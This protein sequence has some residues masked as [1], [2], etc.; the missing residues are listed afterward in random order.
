MTRFRNCLLALGLATFLLPAAP[1][2]AGEPVAA[3]P[4]ATAPVRV[5]AIEIGGAF[6]RATLPGAPVAGGFLTLVNTGDADDRLLAATAAFAAETQIHEMAMSGDVMTMR[7][8]EDG[9]AVP[10][11]ATVHLVPG[12]YHLMF[13]GLKAPL[14]E[15]EHVAVTLTF[16]KAGTAVIDLAVAGAAAAAPEGMEHGA[17]AH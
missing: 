2:L 5:G 15:G 4:A 6:T 9:I 7:R 14:L 1:L 17:M 13:M 11:G 3:S 8:L 12:G 10:A 16:E